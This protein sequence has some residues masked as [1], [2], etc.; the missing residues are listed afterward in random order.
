MRPVSPCPSHIDR[1]KFEHCLRSEPPPYEVCPSHRGAEPRPGERQNFSPRATSSPARLGDRS[2]PIECLMIGALARPRV[3]RQ[4][5]LGGSPV[6]AYLFVS[7]DGADGRL[8]H[9]WRGGLSPPSTAF[10]ADLAALACAAL[11]LF[12]DFD[13]AYTPTRTSQRESFYR[14]S[15]SH[16]RRGFMT[17]TWRAPRRAAEPVIDKPCRAPTAMLRTISSV[18]HSHRDP[19]CSVGRTTSS[20]ISRGDRATSSHS[21]DYSPRCAGIGRSTLVIARLPPTPMLHHSRRDAALTVPTIMLPRRR[22]SREIPSRLRQGRDRLQVP[23]ISA[24]ARPLP[25]SRTQTH[26]H[27]LASSSAA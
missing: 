7:V 1:G 14:P 9:A 20:P 8:G 27:M 11:D 13:R 17:P 21:G 15:R 24:A 5:R 25:P 26:C 12:G 3:A 2:S 22:S 16:W 19:F 23:P 18:L 10:A 6:S 4:G